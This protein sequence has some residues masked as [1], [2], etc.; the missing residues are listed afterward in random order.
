MDR[1]Q[2]IMGVPVAL[3]AVGGVTAALTTRETTPSRGGSKMR[4]ETDVE[5]AIVGGGPAGLSAALILGRSRRKTLLFDAGA[6]RNAPAHAAHNLYTRDGTSPIELNRIAREQLEPYKSVEVRQKLVRDVERREDGVFVLESEDGE[7]T[8]AGY[9]ILATG[10]VDE[11]PPIKGLAELWG[12]GVF[13]C[14]YCHGWEVREQPF[15]LLAQSEH[16]FHFAQ[17]L[18]G[19][20]SDITLC[21]VSPFSLEPEQASELEALG[22]RI[23]PSV[24]ELVGAPDGTVR[25]VILESGEKLGAAAVFTT[26]PIRQRSP[27]PEK[28]GCSFHDE[29]FLK[30]LVKVDPQGS[31]GV[32]GLF[33]VGDAS[34]GAPMVV[35]AAYEG[36]FAGA[37]IN[38]ELLLAGKLPRG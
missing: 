6:P 21:P 1:R 28:L 12:T 25:D 30:G 8:T 34:Q 2:F 18:R 24:R 11:L 38:G 37:S 32:D 13:H 33:V 4:E 14:P 35:A 3:L 20:S 16:A 31:T 27:F 15:V 7:K 17:I 36:S 23:K 26:A 22:V 10:V 19:W 29:G 5:V 9:L